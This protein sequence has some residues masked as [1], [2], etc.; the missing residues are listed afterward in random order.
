MPLNIV[1]DSS[2]NVWV[3]NI[4]DNTVTE[5]VGL[6]RG[7]NISPIEDRNGEGAETGERR[8]ILI[9]MSARMMIYKVKSKRLNKA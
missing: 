1:A 9:S 4:V 2:G 3:I 8:R 7:P 6:A 5:F